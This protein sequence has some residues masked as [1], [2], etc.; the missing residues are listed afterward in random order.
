VAIYVARIARL[1]GRG[2][3]A[4]RAV[5]TGCAAR[6]TLRGTIRR[7]MM[8][9]CGSCTDVA[10]AAIPARMGLQKGILR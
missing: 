1:T 2:V 3:T 7:V 4:R 9:T 10:N 6:R 5:R 8:P